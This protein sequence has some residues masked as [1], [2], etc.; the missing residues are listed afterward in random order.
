MNP[1]Q[2]RKW[3]ASILSDVYKPRPREG[4]LD[5]ASKNV[6]IPPSISPD[7][8][9]YYDV[10]RTPLAEI[11]FEFYDGTEYDEFIAPKSSQS[12]LSQASHTII[13]YDAQFRGRDIILA[14][15]SEP[16]ARKIGRKRIR[17][18]LKACKALAA[19]LGQSMNETTSGLTLYLRGLA[20]YLMGS[21]SPSALANKTAGL[22]IADECDNYPPSPKG[23]SNALDLLRDRLKKVMGA[24]L[25]A[26]SKPK[27]EDTL[28]WPEYLTGTRHKCFVPC[29]HCSN[30][31]GGLDGFQELVWEQIKFGHCKD[32]RDAWDY[33]KV[34][35]LTFYECLHCQGEISEKEKPWLLENR[36]WEISNLGQDDHKPRPRKMSAHISDLYSLHAK[37]TWGRLASEWIDAQKSV[38]KKMRFVRGRLGLPWK[39]EQVKI[40]MSDIRRM[41]SGYRRDEVPAEPDLVLMGIDVQKDVKKWVKAAIRGQD[42][43]VTNWGETLSFQGLVPIADTPT[44]VLTWP[45]G[46]PEADRQDPV[47]YKGLI[48]E[49]G[50][51]GNQTRT[52][53]FVVDTFLGQLPGGGLDYRFYSSYGRGGLSV[54]N[55]RDIIEKTPKVHKGWPLEVYRF[56]D[57]AFK[58]E[59][60]EQRF[61]RFHEIAEALKKGQGDPGLPRIYFPTTTAGDGEISFEE[62][63]RELIAERREWDDAKKRYAWIDPTDPNDYGDALKLIIIAWYVLQPLIAQMKARKN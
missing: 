12:G 52:R 19:K 36:R 58:T 5:W 44:R 24:K 48:D 42:L 40:E 23:E 49:G 3:F 33:E 37:D 1:A 20:I 6:F 62:L 11:V 17:P 7:W 10:E 14:L 27:D 46:T 43:Y 29:P 54:K 26:F 51:A 9:G 38:S 60:Y 39:K 61:G 50:E 55:W 25:I 47:V 18:L 34:E 57:D 13:A 30:Q 41:V 4:V 56:N 8:P 16:E 32:E 35:A 22:A 21:F 59:L 31:A 2:T 45:D 53:D 63:I 28:I 15:D